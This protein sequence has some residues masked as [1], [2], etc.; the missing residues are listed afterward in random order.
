M[1][2]TDSEYP[3]KRI[4]TYPSR[5]TR[6]KEE[7]ASTATQPKKKTP[8]A[9]L[10]SAELCS[11]VIEEASTIYGMADRLMQ[12]LEGNIKPTV[13]RTPNDAR[14]AFS[15]NFWDCCWQTTSDL[16]DELSFA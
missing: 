10:K 12:E 13:P 2:V 1:P 3:V 6:C 8:Y 9:N 14:K 16:H 15:N 7:E 4:F 5:T 11:K